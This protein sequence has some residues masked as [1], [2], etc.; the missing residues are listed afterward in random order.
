MLPCILLGKDL[1][2]K[3]IASENRQS[4]FGLDALRVWDTETAFRQLQRLGQADTRRTAERRLRALGLLPS[5]LDVDTLRDEYGRKSNRPIL[6]W[7]IARARQKRTRVLFIQLCDLP[8][9]KP[10]L[11]AND[12]RGARFWLPLPARKMDGVVALQSVRKLRRHIGRPIAVFPHGELVRYLRDAQSIDDDIVLV[13]QI[14]HSPLPHAPQVHRRQQPLPAYLTRLE[15]ASLQLIREAIADARNPAMLYSADKHSSVLLHLVHKA[16]HPSPPP[17]PLLH[18]DT[19]WQSQEAILFRDA[20]AHASSMELLIYN[21]PD[22]RDSVPCA[23]SSTANRAMI[24]AELLHQALNHHQFDVAFSGPR[25]DGGLFRPSPWRL[26]N[27]RTPPGEHLLVFPLVEWT[28]TD[29]WLYIY[30]ENIPVVSLYFSHLRPVVVRAGKLQLV[31]NEHCRLL[32]GETMRVRRVRCPAVE[33]YSHVGAVESNASSPADIL[34]E[35]IASPRVG[36]T[37]RID[38]DRAAS[39]AK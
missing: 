35:L 13:A 12:A 25:D 31:D 10:C 3:H 5:A 11:H 30:L 14:H 39:H 18:I 21:A 9:G 2:M 15:A 6:D 38:H 27:S 16:F 23:H 22:E 34:R 33:S 28:A 1:R 26:G 32:P 4:L 36:R 7:A 37:A 19:G 29:I 20:M 24:Y 17:M 8:G